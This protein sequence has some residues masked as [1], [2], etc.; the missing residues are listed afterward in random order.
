MKDNSHILRYI[1]SQQ[2]VA[3]SDLAKKYSLSAPTIRRYIAQW[4]T[5][6]LVT[7]FHGHVCTADSSFL[8]LKLRMLSN[9]EQKKL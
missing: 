5:E 4:E 7:R 1:Q 6:A 3:L 9:V 2:K 8:A